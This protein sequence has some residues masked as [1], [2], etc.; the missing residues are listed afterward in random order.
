MNS[1]VAD[2]DA[3]LICLQVPGLERLAYIQLAAAAAKAL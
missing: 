2:R 3:I 1:S